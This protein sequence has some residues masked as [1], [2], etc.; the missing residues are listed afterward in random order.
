[1]GIIA[2]GS[3]AL[4]VTLDQVTKFLAV[5][6]LRPVASITIIEGIFDLCYVENDGAAFG[7][8][9]GWRWFFVPLTV[10]ILA[11]VF[12]YYR[13]LAKTKQTGW[14]RFALILIAAGAL[15]NC[16]D[17]FRTGYVVDFFRV[18]FIDFPVFNVAD[19]CLVVGALLFALLYL[20][21]ARRA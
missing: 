9:Q 4:L 11:A 2:I 1:M 10:V 3:I 14:T 7:I 8:M 18:R 19:C 17:R 16:I 15:G 5:R 12:L 13:S 21:E 20:L 6:L